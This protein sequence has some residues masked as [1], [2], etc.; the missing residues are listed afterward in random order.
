[1]ERLENDLLQEK[2]EH[3]AICETL[4]ALQGTHSDL[5]TAHSTLQQTHQQALASVAETEQA[6]QLAAEEAR[7][8][9][10]RRDS[11]IGKIAA[12]ADAAAEEGTARE[13][14]ESRL[15]V[16]LFARWSCLFV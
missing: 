10:S 14:T 2:Q 13:Q 12:A 3:A 5:Q 9:R 15:Q 7:E 8:M 1:M 6:K 4:A 16:P 11:A